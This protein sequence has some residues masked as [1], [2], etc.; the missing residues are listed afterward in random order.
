MKTLKELF[1]GIACEFINISPDSVVPGISS[2]SRTLSPG[3]IFF[4]LKG[5]EKDGRD[6]IEEAMRRGAAAV[7]CEEAPAGGLGGAG[8]IVARGAADALP[9][10]ASRFFAEPAGR[11]RVVGITGTNGKTTTSHLLYDI[12]ETSGRPS[13]LT[14]TVR[15]VLRGEE[16]AATNTTPDPILL[17]SLL[18][19]AADAGCTNAV[20]EVSSHALKQSRV[21]RIKFSTAAVTNVTG[22]HMDYHGS[23]EDYV[24]SKKLLFTCLDDKGTAILNAD[25]EFYGEFKKAARRGA[26]SYGIRGDCDFRAARIE[27]DIDGSGFR[28]DTPKGSMRVRT[29]LVGMH[30]IYNVLAAIAVSFAEGV[31]PGAIVEAIGRFRP[32]PGR[33]EPVSAGQGFRAFVDYAHTHDALEK[34]LASLRGMCAGRLV[35]VFGC[36]GDRDRSKRARMGRAAARLADYVVLTNDNPRGEDPDS[37]LTEIERGFP[38]GFEAY[39]K[40]PDRFKAIEEALKGRDDS[41]IVL[42]AGKGHEDRQIIGGESFLFNDKAAAEKILRTGLYV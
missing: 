16:M 9:L 28:V 7:C 42:I 39:K 21:S 41:D 40:I 15:Y 33:L 24:N 34:V 4:A 25:D 23:M 19:R 22:D 27:S 2:D 17:Q 38:N 36:G 3:D 6:F 26:L 11:L 14:G 35:V 1:N 18:R 13:L 12:L 5:R 29:N 31:E 20:I 10:L 37:I 30:N 32:A 8:L